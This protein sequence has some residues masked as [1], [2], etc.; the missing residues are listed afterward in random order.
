VVRYF[1]SSSIEANFTSPCG[2]SASIEPSKIEGEEHWTKRDKETG[3]FM[4][5]KKDDE[6]FR[7][8]REH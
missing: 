1:C 5:Q 3:Q 7:V 2:S 4:D 6:K 8:T